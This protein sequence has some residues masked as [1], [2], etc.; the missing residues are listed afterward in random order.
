MVMLPSL[1]LFFA[2]VF[3]TTIHLI[4][5]KCMVIYLKGNN[6]VKEIKNA[7]SSENTVYQNIWETQGKQLPNLHDVFM[8]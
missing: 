6:N 5:K 3:K 8:H 7:L 1:K 2:Q 4:S